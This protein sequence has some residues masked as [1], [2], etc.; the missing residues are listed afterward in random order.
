[1]VKAGDRVRFEAPTS[2]G[3]TASWTARVVKIDDNGVAFVRH[4]ERART[5]PFSP[6]PEKGLY[7]YA[8]FKLV[9]VRRVK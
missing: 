1:M 4:P 9:A 8:A 2:N 3:G 6:V 5:M 7:K